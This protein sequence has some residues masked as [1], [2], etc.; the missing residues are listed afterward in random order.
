M[1]SEDV[2]LPLSG[3]QHQ[4]FCPRQCAL[5]FLELYWS[6]NYLTASGTVMHEAAHS[7][8]SELRGDVLTTRSLRLRSLRLGV[9]GIADVV[10]F[11]RVDDPTNAVKLPHRRGYWIPYPV[12]YKHGSPK[13]GDCD[14]IQLCAQAICLEETLGC[15]IEEGAL[16]YGKT[17]RRKVVQFDERLRKET[18]RVA[19]EFHQTIDSG[20]LPPPVLT[21]AC[22]SCSL[23]DGCMPGV[24]KSAKRYIENALKEIDSDK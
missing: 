10:E 1:Y 12:E 21:P 20:V 13:K 5:M 17:K 24:A 3:V 15:R 9:S 4:S 8:K 23:V 16:F 2:L 7:E 22:K 11:H 18:D 14:E 19:K 6:D